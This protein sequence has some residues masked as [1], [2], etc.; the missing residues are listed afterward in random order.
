M[1]KRGL[2]IAVRLLG[3]GWYV[4]V[5]ILVGVG[6][7]LWIDDQ[8]NASPVFTLLGVLLGSALAFYGLYRMVEFLFKG[9]D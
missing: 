5:S 1:N 8:L 6:G 2:I 9:N 4:A 7:G 3:L